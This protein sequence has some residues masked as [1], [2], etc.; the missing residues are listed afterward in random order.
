MK[1]WVYVMSNPSLP[2]MVKIGYSMK[3]P[4]MRAGNDFDPAGLPDDY[5]VEYHGLVE[6]PKEIE[7]Q[8]HAHLKDRR[9][10]K[11]WFM[12]LPHEAVK[13]I[14]EINST[15]KIYYEELG[16]SAERPREYTG[17][18]QHKVLYLCQKCRARNESTVCV[19]CGLTLA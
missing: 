5:V 13:A 1:G 16:R 12:V 14:R 9:Y 11:E 10:K 4:H 17:S 2:G 6:N 8:V 19:N 3:D 18:D 7:Q 15:G